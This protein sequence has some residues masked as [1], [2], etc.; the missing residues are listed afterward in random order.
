MTNYYKVGPIGTGTVAGFNGSVWIT[1]TG[2]AFT[3]Q[4][5]AGDTF[6]MYYSG[7][8]YSHTVSSITSNVLMAVTPAMTVDFTGGAHWCLR[9]SETLLGSIPR[10]EPDRARVLTL[11]GNEVEIGFIRS[12]WV[13]GAMTTTQWYTARSLLVSGGYSGSCLVQTRLDQIS[14]GADVYAIYKAIITFP[15]PP[16][17]DRWGSYYQNVKLDFILTEAVVP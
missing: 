3:T 4:Y 6:I 13:F 10:S 17:I 5:A 9:D 1:G 7:S 12:S 15:R 14:G 11:S 16:E 2:T 8:Y